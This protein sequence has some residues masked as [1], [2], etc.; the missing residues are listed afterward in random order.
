MTAP[1]P[2][3]KGIDDHSVRQI[4]YSDSPQSQHTPLLMLMTKRGRVDP[5]F[6]GTTEFD[7]LYD[8]ESLS[9]SSP[10]HTHQSEL[11][12]IAIESGNSTVV[13]KRIVDEDSKAAGTCI[14]VNPVTLQLTTCPIDDV[15]SKIDIGAFLPVLEFKC[16]DPGAWGNRI[17]IQ[18][19][20]APA[21]T[22]NVMGVGIDAVVYEA[23]VM[24]EDEISGNTRVLNNL[25]GEPSTLF[26]LRPGSVY[27]NV[28]YYFD[29]IMRVSYIQDTAALTRPEYFEY[30][31]LHA[32]VV[33]TLA[34]NPAT[35][36]KEDVLGDLALKG[37]PLFRKNITVYATSGSDG[38]LNTS[39][40]AV[41]NIIDRARKYEDAVRVWLSGIDD[42]SSIVDMAQFPY[43]TLWDSGFIEETKKAFKNL[44]NYRKDI[45]IAVAATSLYRYI[46]DPIDDT[47]VFVGNDKLTNQETISMGTYYRSIFMGI[48]ESLEYGTPTVRATLMGQ[49]G[50]N[51]NTTYRKRQSLNVDLFK[52]VCNYCGAGTGRWN[53]KYAFDQTG[54]ND[55][56][57]WQ[58]ISMDYIS[59]SITDNAWDAGLIYV[60]S[61]DT[62]KQFYPAY[63]TVYPD[64]T[65]VLNNVFTMMACCWINKIHHKAWTTVTGN[66]K[67]TDL[68][69]AERLDQ[70]INSRLMNAFDGRFITT[71]KTFYTPNDQANGFSFT[72]ETTIYCNVTKR[73]ANYKIIAHRMSEL[74]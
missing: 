32:D 59:P 4:P 25:Y 53:S 55:I 49:D 50:V 68:E 21:S 52:K 63:Q 7:K 15:E 57:G 56:S 45:W 36:W 66:S 74:L 6:I 73:V 69:I 8:N 58:D 31:T 29:E 16:S 39:L 23:V 40:S 5:C 51:R 35:Y 71:A 37:N 19:F 46:K 30:F 24:I 54:M 61:L 11:M 17:G 3:L 26:T 1:K 18:V 33:S 67:H 62:K 65:S 48:P 14:G 12:R 60:Q 13:I 34:V 9:V 27:N 38:F 43:S 44:L 10:W 22:Q 20:K 64:D 2:I 42:T 47:Y 28:D 70:Y 41:E 72:T